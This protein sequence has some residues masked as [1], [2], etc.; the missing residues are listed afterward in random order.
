MSC[1]VDAC[2]RT[3]CREPG[4]DDAFRGMIEAIAVTEIEIMERQ[5]FVI[6]KQ[7]TIKE[8]I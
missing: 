8:P 4:R 1:R 5:L 2:Q 3:W 7:K 6:L